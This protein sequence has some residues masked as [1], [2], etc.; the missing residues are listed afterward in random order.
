MSAIRIVRSAFLLILVG[1]SFC[2]GNPKAAG[3]GT[4]PHATFAANI[5][6]SWV[7]HSLLRSAENETVP[8]NLGQENK[9]FRNSQSI[10]KARGDCSYIVNAPSF[11]SLIADLLH[12]ASFRGPPSF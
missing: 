7:G 11:H 1:S 10:A 3:N 2:M 4:P 9:W 5:E 12:S 6:Y 8:S